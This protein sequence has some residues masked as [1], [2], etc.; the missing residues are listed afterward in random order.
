VSAM[1]DGGALGYLFQHVD[2]PGVIPER[3][4]IFQRAR[5]DRV[6]R[7]QILSNVKLGKEKEVEEQV[8]QYADPRGSSTPPIQAVSNC[9]YSDTRQASRQIWLSM[10]LMIMGERCCKTFLPSCVLT[11]CSYDV[12]AKCDGLMAASFNSR[13]PA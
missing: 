4:E 8:R 10:L 9:S 6:A 5:A 11:I 12:F 3:L 1:E 7:V 13:I 2:D